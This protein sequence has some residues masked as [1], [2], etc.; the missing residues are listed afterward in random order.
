L[1]NLENEGYLILQYRVEINATLSLNKVE[2]A[3]LLMSLLLKL[4][5]KCRQ[6]ETERRKTKRE[7]V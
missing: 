3:H 5:D 6:D 1:P 2:K 4:L 7:K